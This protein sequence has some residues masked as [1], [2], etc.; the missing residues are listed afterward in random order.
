M[1]ALLS[2]ELPV[3]VRFRKIAPVDVKKGDVNISLLG[4][5][6][7]NDRGKQIDKNRYC[8]FSTLCLKENT[9]KVPP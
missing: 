2:V 7:N 1:L 5:A 8:F 9:Q 3:R 6:G 4:L